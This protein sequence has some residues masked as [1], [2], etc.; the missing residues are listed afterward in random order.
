MKAISLWQPW[1]SLLVIGAKVIETRSW[2]TQYR[3]PLLIHAAKTLN[4]DVRYALCD[5]NVDNAFRRQGGTAARP[6][7]LPF[8][9]IVG[10]V[11]LVDCR[12]TES[13]TAE[14]LDTEC[15]FEHFQEATWTEGA[16]GNFAP[17]RFGWVLE[18]PQ[19]F[20]KPIP[21][22]G[23]QGFFEVSETLWLGSDYKP[24]SGILELG[25]LVRR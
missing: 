11:D 1:A 9:A 3:G 22:K 25:Q 23:S 17:G 5:T 19:K 10:Q 20:E 15:F 2:P 7:W 8:G 12:P 4:Q 21:Y 13:F 16:L 6:L 18:K 14:E 24:G